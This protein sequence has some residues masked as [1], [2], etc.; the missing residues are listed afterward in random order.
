M[1]KEIP[2]MYKIM[3]DGNPYFDPKVFEVS[4]DLAFLALV[5]KDNRIIVYRLAIPSS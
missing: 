2:K 1:V 5:T 4:K 3:I